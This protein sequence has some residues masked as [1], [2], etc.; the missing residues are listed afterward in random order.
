M[1]F[2][3]ALSVF[4]VSGSGLAAQRLRMALIAQNIANANSIK[5]ADGQPFKRKQAV[6]AE[7][8][9]A[10]LGRTD[11]TYGSFAGCRLDRI[12][13]SP[14]EFK[15]VYNP[16]HPLA[17]EKG[18][19]KMPNVDTVVEMYEMVSASRSYE[20]NLAVMKTYRQMLERALN[21]LK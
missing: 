21:F 5:G 3:D 8:I 10:E 14:V 16:N 13:T 12:L 7:M 9:D 6:F 19:V 2:R 11:P 17:D 18:F 20:A 4:D 1:S 15:A